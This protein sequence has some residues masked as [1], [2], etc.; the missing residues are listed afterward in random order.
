MSHRMHHMPSEL[1]GGERQ[2]VSVARSLINHPRLILADEPTGNLD[3]ANAAMIGELLFSLAARYRTTLILV[4]H[5][6]ELA[7]RASLRYRLKDGKLH[8][9]S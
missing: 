4:T 6:T 5:D 3:P 9:E 8:G 2:R 1:S 7:G